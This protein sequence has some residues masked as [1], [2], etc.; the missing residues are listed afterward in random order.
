MESAFFSSSAPSAIITEDYQVRLANGSF[1]KFVEAS[2]L[3]VEYSDSVIDFVDTALQ[4]EV[5]RLI[6]MAASYGRVRHVAWVEDKVK[7]HQMAR[8][9][10]CAVGTCWP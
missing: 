10:R 8:Q 1:E 3:L 6:G 7:E 9:C 2:H 5:A 4:D